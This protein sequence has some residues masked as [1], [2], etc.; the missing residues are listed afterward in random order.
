MARPKRLE[1]YPV[2]PYPTL[3]EYTCERRAFLRKLACGVVA[4]GAGRLLTACYSTRD[5][6]GQAPERDLHEVRLPGEGFVSAYMRY[7]EYLRYAVTFTTYSAPLADY[8][9][10]AE[11]EG[12][13]VLS[14]KLFEFECAAMTD[15]DRLPGVRVAL[16][17]ALE[18]NFASHVTDDGPRIHSLELIVE[19]CEYVGTPDGGVSMPDFP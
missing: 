11:E 6:T 2:Q 7:D 16:V 15:P 18:N 13:E 5:I 19:S 14:A 17:E 1:S 12:T 4:L 10:A 9:R 3:E 8:Y